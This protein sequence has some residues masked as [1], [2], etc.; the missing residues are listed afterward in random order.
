MREYIGIFILSF[1]VGLG[2]GMIFFKILLTI[3]SED[4]K[5]G[6]IDALTGNVK[7]HLVTMPDSTREWRSIK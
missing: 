5:G 4:Y 7:Y 3:A 2:V 6:Q 1:I